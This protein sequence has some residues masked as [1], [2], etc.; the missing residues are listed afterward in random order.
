MTGV[1]SCQMDEINGGLEVL[2]AENS[3]IGTL[4][5]TLSS[6]DPTLVNY[7]IRD[8]RIKIIAIFGAEIRIDQA[9]ISF[10]DDTTRD[11]T[12]E[13]EASCADGS[14]AVRV[15]DLWLTDVD[16]RPDRISSASPL[17]MDENVAGPQV[18]G[19]FTVV[20]QDGQGNFGR[21]QE[22]TLNLSSMQPAI[23]YLDGNKLMCNAT[24]D[25]ETQPPMVIEVTAHG[26]AYADEFRGVTV[27]VAAGT[28]IT[29]QFEVHLNDVNESP[30]IV[31]A[32]K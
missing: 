15:F 13:V 9:N 29:T 4:V 18:V 22:H 3:P 26:L 16:E 12:V 28:T 5:A 30:T 27:P 25:Y 10:E 31:G 21:A 24:L 14:T 20:D 7:R 11:T 2:V 6:S 32:D 17:S 19:Q 23:F 1:S 8:S